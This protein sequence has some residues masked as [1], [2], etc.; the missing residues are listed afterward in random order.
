MSLFLKRMLHEAGTVQNEHLLFSDLHWNCLLF[1]DLAWNISEF[2]IGFATF[3]AHFI[4]EIHWYSH[5]LRIVFLPMV[6]QNLQNLCFPR[7]VD[8]KT[9]NYLEIFSK[10]ASSELS[11]SGE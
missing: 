6:L 11:H 4:S 9:F 3:H 8:K 2:R 10:R 7:L 5:S 1:S